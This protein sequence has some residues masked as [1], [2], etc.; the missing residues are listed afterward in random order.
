MLPA[1]A[2]LTRPL[3][4]DSRVESDSSDFRGI[5]S[6]QA[7]FRRMGAM[8]VAAFHQLLKLGRTVLV[9]DVDTVW[10]WI[11]AS[12]RAPL[13]HPSHSAPVPR[14]LAYARC[15]SSECTHQSHGDRRTA[16]CVCPMCVPQVWTADPQE[17]FASLPQKVR[18]SLHRPCDSARARRAVP[19][20]QFQ[21]RSAR[22]LTDI[23]FRPLLPPTHLPRTR[24]TL[25][26]Q[27]IASPAK[28]T[29][30]NTAETRASTHRACGFAAT[31]LAIPSAR[32]S[33]QA[34]STCDPR[35]RPSISPHAGTPSWRRRPTTGTWR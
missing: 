19:E 3:L 18:R 27:A 4:E 10:T 20:G 23:S 6:D 30:I 2:A 14:A 7:R 12:H 28:P 25:E 22:P 21:K 1:L 24:S 33:I 35:R 8:K 16:M 13:L 11:L 9:S 31:T 26:S 5:G 15:L 32:H 29:R 34:S 17:Y